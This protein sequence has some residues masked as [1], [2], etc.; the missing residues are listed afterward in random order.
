MLSNVRLAFP[1][2]FEAKAVN[3][4][5][6]PAFS[7]SFL[8]TPD[9][10]DL[11]KLKQAIKEVAEAKW[12][13]K[14]DEILRGLVAADK[15]C[16]HNGDTKSQYDGYAGNFF[17]SARG[18]V[19]PLII[20]RDRSQ[21]SEADGKPYSGCY[22]NARISLWAQQNN[23]GK[24][25]NAQLQ[26]VQFF[27]DGEAFGGGRVASADEFEALDNT[28]DDAPPDAGGE[29]EDDPMAGLL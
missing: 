2:L 20:D 10:P 4:G 16:L 27:A 17:V 12:K 6:K 9:H 25:I 3:Q 15:V 8:L 18:Q 7:A 24:R 19:R 14:A 26:G 23:Y 21:L 5:D 11:P 1:Q 22:V 29:F 28:A 13:D